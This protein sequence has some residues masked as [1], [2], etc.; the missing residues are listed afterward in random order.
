MKK[1]VNQVINEIFRQLTLTLTLELDVLVR[2]MDAK[3]LILQEIL[4]LVID[5]NMFSV[6]VIDIISS[7]SLQSQ[8]VFINVI[9]PFSTKLII[10]RK[11]VL[12][13]N[14]IATLVRMLERKTLSSFFSQLMELFHRTIKKIEHPAK[15]E[16]FLPKPLTLTLF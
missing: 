16:L 11:K 12:L 1:L 9:N 3:G 13:G 15:S 6:L 5:Y 4:L 2:P 14:F 10:G 7:A 8:S